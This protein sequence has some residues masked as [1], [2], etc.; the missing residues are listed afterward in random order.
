MAQVDFKVTVW[1]RV[2]IPD[3]KLNDVIERIRSGEISSSSD[4]FYVLDDDCTY[5]GIIDDTMEPLTPE[6]NDNQST[7]EAMT[8]KGKTVFTNYKNR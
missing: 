3:D 8:N 6:E 2:N 5:E 7:I 4:L 1:E